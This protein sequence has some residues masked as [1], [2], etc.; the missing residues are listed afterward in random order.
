[1]TDLLR[2]DLENYLLD[3]I[4]RRFSSEFDKKPDEQEILEEKM[5]QYSNGH[6]DGRRDFLFKILRSYEEDHGRDDLLD[7]LETHKKN[8][9]L[10]IL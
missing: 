2:E 1:M 8:I 9:E 3:Y 10:D 4:K 7:A 6:Y 5:E